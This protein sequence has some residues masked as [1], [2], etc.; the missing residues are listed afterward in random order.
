MHGTTKVGDTTFVNNPISGRVVAL[1]PHKVIMP[2]DVVKKNY[3]ILDLNGLLIKRYKM[4]KCT[5]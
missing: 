3:L 1:G 2:T 5:C 4:G